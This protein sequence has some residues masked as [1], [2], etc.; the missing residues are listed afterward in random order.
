MM[1]PILISVS[2][3]PGSYFF[4]AIAAVAASKAATAIVA[5]TTRVAGFLMVLSLAPRLRTI[6]AAPGQ[7]IKWADIFCLMERKSALVHPRT[8]VL[9]LP[10]LKLANP[11]RGS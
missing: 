11:R 5:P 1:L 6:V 10:G 2:F 3:A 4:C 8:D 7:P 9:S